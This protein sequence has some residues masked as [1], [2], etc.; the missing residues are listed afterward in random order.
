MKTPVAITGGASGIGLAA[1]ERLLEDGWPVAIVDQDENA[2]GDAEE[3]LDGEDAIFLAADVTDEDV[4]ADVFDTIVDAMGPLSGLVNS[5]GI[6]RDIPA[7]E[8]S[9]ELFRQI[10]DIN[11]VG[12][13][14]CAKAAVERMGDTLSIV[15]IGSIA[16]LLG[17]KGRVA[18]GASKAAV[19][20]MTEVMAN[21]LGTAGVRVNCV[22]PGPVETPLI[23]RLHTP[24]DRKI[25]LDR[26]PQRRYCA[27][28]EIA[29]AI[30][31]LISP[32]A[33]YITGHT[34]AVDGGFS[35]AGIMDRR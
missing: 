19:K 21:E 9:P 5:A 14:I 3:R 8:T 20:L 10:L 26:V 24:E 29:A 16:G 31:F 11:V 15:N 13:F 34:L 17:S 30:A 28:S 27:P 32:D 6:A 7:L 23:A 4:I 2:L 12:S 22:A 35:V 1:A 18:Y 25:W 33:S